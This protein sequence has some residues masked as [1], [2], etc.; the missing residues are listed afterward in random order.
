[1]LALLAACALPFAANA[2]SGTQLS[3]RYL[4]TEAFPF[5][6]GYLAARDATGAPISDLQP[7]ELRALEDSVPLLIDQL[8]PMQPGVRVVLLITPSEAFAIRD[9]QART[10]FDYL[11]QTLVDWASSLPS[12]SNTAISLLT[13]EGT[14]TQ[15]APASE[16][17]SAFDAYQPD[18]SGLQINPQALLQAIEIAGQPTPQPGM[19]AAIWWITSTPLIE[20]LAAI[21]DWQ[22]SLIDLGVPLFLWQVD[23]P[24]T[25]ESPAGLALRD[26][27]V[28]SGG[29]FFSFSGTEAFPV[30]EE[31]FSPL[32][33]AYY[34]QYT[35]QV[36]SAGEH[37]VA[38]QL[39]REGL[40]ATSAPRSFELNLESPNP[41][42]VSPPAQIERLPSENDPQLLAPFSQPIE[43]LV[44]FPDG[45]ER[46][47]AR[48]TLYVNDTVV[49]ENRTAP[50]NHFA[51]D[52]TPY[53]E[54]Q[55]VFLRVEAEDTLGLVGESIEI[56]V[57]ITTQ[58]PATWFQALL[59]RGAPLLAGSIVLIAAAAFFLVMVLSGRINPAR[60]TAR[61]TR[62]GRPVHPPLSTDPLLD[63]PLSMQQDPG[64][65][66]SASLDS[67]SVG[68][69]HVAPA[70][71]QRLAMQG[72]DQSAPL[73]ALDDDQLLIGADPASDLRLTDESVDNQHARITSL[74]GSEFHIADLGS[75]A[76]TWVN[77][78][79]VSLEGSRL[80]D[81]DLVH[82]GRVAFR[83]LLNPAAHSE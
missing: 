78:A 54:S 77:Y 73:L 18:L 72:P 50:F 37:Q 1:L 35:S 48:T 75:E 32:R 58:A 55:Q 8:R 63:S 65:E 71:L 29:Q 81:G 26:L 69:L 49:A 34:F 66:L 43:I 59:A 13:P 70:Y 19:G 4:Q 33:N 60:F 17:L 22:Q 3:I 57:E 80:Q 82:I 11:R 24:S 6:T 42:L 14:L 39:Q 21:P 46:S 53:V 52:L 7:A 61:R 79:P 83:F 67:E 16:W 2:Q 74:A 40:T 25:F 23:A 76:G 68:A 15:D 51:W 27:A 45:F 36:R 12:S 62:R 41:I 47:L 31:Y 64:D 10:R 44:E 20:S 9:S 30:P 38:I 28:A 56:P 5:V